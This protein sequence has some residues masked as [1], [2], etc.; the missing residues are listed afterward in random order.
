MSL[1]VLRQ[2]VKVQFFVPTVKLIFKCINDLLLNVA[3]SRK[4]KLGFAVAINCPKSL[5]IWLKQ[6]FTILIH[7][8][9][10][11]YIE[12]FGN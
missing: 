6:I 12:I 5:I 7:C 8:S 11:N 10:E 9:I 2:T 4:Y 1:R 3:I